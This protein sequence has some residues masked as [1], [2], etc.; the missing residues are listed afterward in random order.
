M[1]SE[2]RE[3]V[4]PVEVG[5]EGGGRRVVGDVV[6][7]ERPL[8]LLER[9]GLVAAELRLEPVLGPEEDLARRP[10]RRGSV[11]IHFH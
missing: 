11:F 6:L 9:L 3:R 8:E 10:P 2:A 5:C 1:I 4:Q 7:E